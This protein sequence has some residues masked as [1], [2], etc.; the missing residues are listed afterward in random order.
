[1]SK[2]MEIINNRYRILETEYSNRIFSSHIAKDILSP[3]E[4]VFRLFLARPQMMTGVDIPKIIA[5]FQLYSTIVHPYIVKDE[6]VDMVFSIDRKIVERTCYY[7]FIVEKFDYTTS[8]LDYAYAQTDAD[9]LLDKF[10]EILKIFDLMIR[11]G[12]CYDFISTEHIYV[13]ENQNIKIKDFITAQIESITYSS[14][15][16]RT[17]IK[18]RAPEMYTGEKATASSVIYALGTLLKN[19]LKN[20]E[21]ETVH[22]AEIKPIADRMTTYRHIERYASIVQVIEDIN[23]F[24]LKNYAFIFED[25]NYYIY[26]KPGLLVRDSVR[27]AILKNANKIKDGNNGVYIYEIKGYRNTGKTKVLRDIRKQLSLNGVDIFASFDEDR[28]LFKNSG[29]F[30]VVSKVLSERGYDI[31]QKYEKVG[32]FLQN[33]NCEKDDYT[34][35]SQITTFIKD[36]IDEQ[37]TAIIID[38]L[39]S[40]DTDTIEII[41][42]LQYDR[43]LKEK[44][45]II[46]TSEDE[47]SLE[48]TETYVLNNLT[49]AETSRMIK[50]ILC[51]DYNPIDIATRIYKDTTGNVKYVKK[52]VLNLIEQNVLEF[53]NKGNWIFKSDKYDD[54]K[55]MEDSFDS[56]HKYLEEFNFIQQETIINLSFFKNPSTVDDVAVMLSDIR[57]SDVVNNLTELVNEN[58]FVTKFSDDGYYYEFEDRLFKKKVYT[59]IPEDLKIEKHRNIAENIINSKKLS[60]ERFL[61]ELIYHLK[62]AKYHKEASIYII[63]KAEDYFDTRSLAENIEIYEDAIIQA[64]LS[65]DEIMQITAYHRAGNVC[66]KEGMLDKANGYFKASLDIA[67]SIDNYKVVFVSLNRIAEVYLKIKDF[68]NAKDVLDEIK[69]ILQRYKSNKA[70][71]DYHVLMISYL[72]KGAEH[73]TALEWIQGF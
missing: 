67:K 9:V 7:Y 48:K 25:K 64:I 26:T 1:M 46:Y 53:D 37:I 51:V 34:S 65:K 13:D 3:N 36:A 63:K 47:I 28:I 54:L 2:Y 73:E 35:Y 31:I 12:F 19:L 44:I 17:E 16:K 62:K 61:D 5:D 20:P 59:S 66:F 24:C 18:Y 50:S 6:H 22:G 29:I 27:N 15:D 68:V 55:I 69:S 56:P 72:T 21:F 43:K 60:N 10:I 32:E 41:R 42:Y 11:R 49:I 71:L 52:I 4:E 40:S 45:L 57:F 33:G 14:H 58:V 8:F 39:R 23:F 70:Q 38:D 30:P